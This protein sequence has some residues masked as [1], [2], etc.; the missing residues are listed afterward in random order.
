M[1]TIVTKPSRFQAT[2]VEYLLLFLN[3]MHIAS[4]YSY[5]DQ[6]PIT[7]TL[8]C[9]IT[10]AFC[11]FFGTIYSLDCFKQRGRALFIEKVEWDFVGIFGWGAFLFIFEN[12]G[13][14]DK[15]CKTHCT[16]F[17]LSFKEKMDCYITFWKLLLGNTSFECFFFILEFLHPWVSKQ[18][19]YIPA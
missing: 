15:Q 6:K 19:A 3:Q 1:S 4:M 14:G 16:C 5:W 7:C 9:S 8:H 18:N 13:S 17:Y 11:F 10:Y 2:T 12:A